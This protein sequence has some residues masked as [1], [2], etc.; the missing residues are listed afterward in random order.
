MKKNTVKAN[1]HTIE[2]KSI[3][4]QAGE[5][6]GGIGAH[7]VNAKDSVM[8]FVSHEFDNT[9]KR[10]KKMGKKVKKAAKKVPVRKLAKK[11]AKKKTVKKVTKKT[12]KKSSAGK[13]K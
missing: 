7:I 6:I 5:V 1:V 13:R 8:D 11:T 4:R 2:E 9:K 12:S 3:F 10:A